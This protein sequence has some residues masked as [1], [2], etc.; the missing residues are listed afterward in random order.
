MID[1]KGT[2]NIDTST[3]A[4]KTDLASLETKVDISHVDKLKIFLAN[5][6][7]LHNVVHYDAVKKTIYDKMVTRVNAI[8]T[9]TPTQ[10]LQDQL[11]K[12][13]MIQPNQGLE[14]KIEDVSK[15]TLNTNRQVKKKDYSKKIN[16]TGNKVPSITRLFINAA[17]NAKAIEIEKDT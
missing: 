6:I 1:L 4:S 17:F 7:R 8:D 10:T 2:T 12:H 13:N 11:L 16:E 14:Q 5:L 9:N 15:K 3:L